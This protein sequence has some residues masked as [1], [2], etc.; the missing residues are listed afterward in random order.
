MPSNNIHHFPFTSQPWRVAVLTVKFIINS[1]EAQ[2]SET[3]I[4]VQQSNQLRYVEDIDIDELLP[5][6]KLEEQE[7]KHE[8]QIN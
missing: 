6:A 1:R 4:E 5:E 8:C 3:T 7:N 2:R